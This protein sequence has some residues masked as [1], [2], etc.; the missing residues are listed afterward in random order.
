MN[1][2]MIAKAN[3][4]V[5]RANVQNA[6]IR[7]GIIESLPVADASV[8]WIV[9]NCVVNLSPERSRV[10]REIARVLKPGGQMLISDIV[11]GPIDEKKL[12]L[13]AKYALRISQASEIAFVEGLRAAGL[14]QIEVRERLVYDAGQ[15]ELVF[16]G[17]PAEDGAMQEM[18]LPL[19]RQAV[20]SVWHAMFYARRPVYSPVAC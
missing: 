4:N 10:F 8:D 12:G 6:E 9:S 15:I 20:G 5:R 1:D 3:E 14:T 13:A 18:L 19:A 11:T 7:K 2:E 16:K 17:L